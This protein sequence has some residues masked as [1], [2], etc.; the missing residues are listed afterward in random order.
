MI[1]LWKIVGYIGSVSFL[2]TVLRV[3]QKLRSINPNLVYGM[4][5]IFNIYIS[6]AYFVLQ[7]TSFGCAWK[8]NSYLGLTVVKD[9]CLL[10]ISNLCLSW[11]YFLPVCDPVMGD[12]GRLYVP[13]ELVSVYREKV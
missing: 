4:C 5:K 13:Q 7:Y 12:E 8:T 11:V 9:T 6:F 1:M 3:V 10:L 2:N